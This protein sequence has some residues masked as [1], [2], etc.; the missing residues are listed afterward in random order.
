MDKQVTIEL[1]H[2]QNDGDIALE[3]MYRSYKAEFFDFGRRYLSSDEDI[4]DIYQDTVIAM[5]EK[6]ATGQ[7]TELSCS[8]KTYLFSIGKHLM[9][10]RYKSN[11]QVKFELF[12]E[13]DLAG[14]IDVY[15]PELS[16]QAE[17]LKTVILQLEDGCQR[18]LTL[19]YYR[20]FNMESIAANLG[21]KNA[22]VVK[23][24]KARC[25]K[26]LRKLFLSS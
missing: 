20:N 16:L 10:N 14:S 19:Y 2:L 21:Y 18:I 15:P 24:H 12:E 4:S 5:Y 1:T 9:I 3:R 23:S 22:N 17:K 26:R 25:M 7:L 13:V 8:V 11:Q 6:V